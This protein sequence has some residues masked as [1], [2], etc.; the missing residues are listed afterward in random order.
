MKLAFKVNKTI[1][2]WKY[3]FIRINSYLFCT[4]LNS[5]LLIS[6]VV[7]SGDFGPFSTIWQSSPSRRCAINLIKLRI[8]FP[9]VSSSI[10]MRLES[11]INL[12]AC[13]V[14]FGDDNKILR[15]PSS[16]TL[17]SLLFTSSHLKIVSVFIL[18]ESITTERHCWMCLV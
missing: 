7:K 10:S 18:S 2:S 17:V 15:M 4:K 14:W 11:L 8:S 3:R 5:L 13:C 1:D 16:Q 6:T 9:L 12:N